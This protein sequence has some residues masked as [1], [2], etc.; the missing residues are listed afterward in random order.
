MRLLALLV[1]VIALPVAEEVCFRVDIQ[2]AL[3]ESNANISG[4]VISWAHHGYPNVPVYLFDLG[5]SAPLRRLVRETNRRLRSI[6]HGNIGTDEV[7]ERFYSKVVKLV[8]KLPRTGRVTSNKA[9]A[10]TFSEIVPGK[11]YYLVAVDV[12]EDGVFYAGKLTPILK[13]GQQLR[14]DL[15]EVNLWYAE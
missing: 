12:T 7:I 15:H 10:Y 1:S 13:A 14:I 3:E 6:G 2:A 11:R 5:Q 9:G 8:P 4:A